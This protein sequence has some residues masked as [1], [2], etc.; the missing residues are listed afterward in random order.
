MTVY[1]PTQL[2]RPSSPKEAVSLLSKLGQSSRLVAGNTTLY[3]FARQGALSDVS[4]LIDMEGM[5][6]SY[7][8]KDPSS[9]NLCIG[10]TTTFSQMAGSP[11]LESPCYL[12]L[13]DAATKITPPQIRNT[14]T[15]AG[16]ICSGIPFY[17]MPT[18]V[19]ALGS[20]MKVLSSREEKLIGVDDFFQD[21]FLTSLAPD[22]MVLELQFSP[23]L[24]DSASSFLKLGR[25]SV[26]FAIVNAAASLTVDRS[27][28]RITQARIALGAVSNVVIRSLAAEEA[29][30]GRRLGGEEGNKIVQTAA[31]AAAN[32]EPTP[33]VHA[34][35]NYKKRVIPVVVRDVLLQAR[36]RL[37]LKE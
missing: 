34:S 31:E 21:Y 18:A 16:S 32:I 3:E 27:S 8:R 23:E 29:L 20:K 28:G 25:L 11:L 14:G 36:D 9:G 30:V 10:C 2:I 5:G 4:Q 24:R 1:N 12:A 13:R 7:V 17:D 37:A 15:V 6:L 33:S 22:E 35:S 26:D 19:M